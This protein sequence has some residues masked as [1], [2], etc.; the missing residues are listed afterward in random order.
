MGFPKYIHKQILVLFHLL[1]NPLSIRLKCIFH[2]V[3][4]VEYFYCDV[5]AVE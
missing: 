3:Q 5:Y 1:H 2:Y 4:S